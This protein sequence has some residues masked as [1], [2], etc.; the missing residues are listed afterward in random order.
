M[1]RLPVTMQNYFEQ[2]LAQLVKFEGCVPWMYLDTVGK[3]TVGVGLMLP[4]PVSAQ[5]LP[6]QSGGQPATPDQIATEFHRVSTLPKSKLPNFYRASTSLELPPQTITDQLRIVLTGFEQ[7]LREAL[8]GYDAF[9]DGVK[10]AL[11]D[12]A[13]NLGPAGLLKEY[14]HFLAAI[15]SGNWTAAAAG[16]TRRGPAPARNEWTRAII[17]SAVPHAIQA[18]AESLAY[19][20]GRLLWWLPKWLLQP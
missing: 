10:Q 2:A 12:M 16:C 19:R 7:K 9:P 8:K 13:Y 1:I 20:L 11:L 17:L 14:P 6:F 15:E 3:V 4:D 18:R 5:A